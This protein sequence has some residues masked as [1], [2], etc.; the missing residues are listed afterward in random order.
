MHAA[1]AGTLVKSLRLGGNAGRAPSLHYTLAFTL[2]LRKNYRKASV[3]FVESVQR[4]SAGHDSFSQLG[5]RFTGCLDW[6]AD[7]H[8][9]QLAFQDSRVSPQSV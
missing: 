3:R 4:N 6:P 8:R 2:Q 1:V 5:S 7:L 9:P